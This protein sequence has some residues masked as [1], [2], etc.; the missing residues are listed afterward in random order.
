MVD[1]FLIF[2]TLVLAVLFLIGL[3]WILKNDKPE[4]SK[5]P[6]KPMMRDD[7]DHT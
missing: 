7:D 5:K 4:E 6:G 1:T 3:I 2:L